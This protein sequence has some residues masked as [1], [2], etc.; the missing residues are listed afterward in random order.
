M[1]SG[2]MG[3]ST[4]YDGTDDHSSDGKRVLSD[5]SSVGRVL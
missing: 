3:I 4:S 2:Y 5:I 1:T